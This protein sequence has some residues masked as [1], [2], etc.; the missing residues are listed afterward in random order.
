MANLQL[1]QNL[2]QMI[3]QFAAS[4]LT[5]FL[6]ATNKIALIIKFIVF[7]IDMFRKL[8]KHGWCLRSWLLNLDSHQRSWSDQIMVR[9]SQ[10]KIVI[11]G[12]IWQYSHSRAWFSHNRVSVIW[13]PA[14]SLYERSR[15]YHSCTVTVCR[16]GLPTNTDSQT[17]VSCM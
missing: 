16:C 11:W 15:L 3:C 14:E 13:L 17:P 7:H 12:I 4:K 10:A 8:T 5:C 2:R 6:L 9:Y 1:C